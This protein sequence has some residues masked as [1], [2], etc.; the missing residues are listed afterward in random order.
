MAT[1]EV[2]ETENARIALVIEGKYGDIT[3]IGLTKPAARELAEKLLR[4]SE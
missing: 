1:I 2:L 3:R 4:M